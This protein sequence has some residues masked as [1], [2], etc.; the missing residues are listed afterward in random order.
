MS[1]SELQLALPEIFIAAMACVVLVAD[2]G[3]L[4]RDLAVREPDVALQGGQGR[5]YG[6]LCH[7]VFSCWIATNPRLLVKYHRNSTKTCCCL[8]RPTASL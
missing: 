8:L 1:V 7:S 2:Q 5:R 6:M 4:A 3:V